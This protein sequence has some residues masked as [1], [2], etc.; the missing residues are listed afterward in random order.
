MVGLA[1]E[2]Q[3]GSDLPAPSGPGA[4][5][6]PPKAEPVAS[7]RGLVQETDSSLLSPP[8]AGLAPGL[9]S[10]P[11][12]L[13]FLLKDALF[14]FLLALRV[15]CKE[16]R[17]TGDKAGG[18]GRPADPKCRVSRVQTVLTWGL[19]ARRIQVGG[20]TTA[21]WTPSEHGSSIRCSMKQDTLLWYCGGGVG[22]RWQLSWAVGPWDPAQHSTAAARGGRAGTTHSLLA[23]G[24]ADG[25]DL[26]AVEGE[27]LLEALGQTGQLGHRGPGPEQGH[28]PPLSSTSFHPGKWSTFLKIKKT[29]NKP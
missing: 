23:P 9:T 18:L 13:D 20:M 15:F 17:A 14:F 10:G 11:F 25:H 5:T 26:L 28:C 1:A 19:R 27:L 29:T 6:D 4:Q 8:A 7:A 2:T 12:L 24:A 22:R 16:S 3:S 21:A